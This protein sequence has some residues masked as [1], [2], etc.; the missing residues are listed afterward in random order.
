[1]LLDCESGCEAY[2]WQMGE[3]CPNSWANNDGGFWCWE[4]EENDELIAEDLEI[5]VID[6]RYTNSS[7]DA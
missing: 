5:G 1:M 2:P 3:H 7:D 6:A 4:C